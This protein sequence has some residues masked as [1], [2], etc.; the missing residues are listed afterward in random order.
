EL[1]ESQTQLFQTAKLATLGEMSTGMAHEMN[2]PMAG[3]S[4]AVTTIKK[5]KEKNRLTDE[6]LASALKDIE[7]SVTRCTKIIRHVRAFARQEALKF[8]EV[9]VNETVSSAL[10]LLAEQLKLRGIEVTQSLASTLPKIQGEPYQLEQV[11][12]NMISNA[13][14]ALEERETESK[15]NNETNYHMQLSLSTQLEGERIVVEITDNGIGMTEE[16][17][18]KVF[19]PF[20]TTKPVGKGTGLGMSIVYGILESHQAKTEIK[21][22]LKKGTSMAVSLR[23]G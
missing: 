21:S 13:R 3:I 9:D 15:A 8:T 1:A 14:D 12:I 7:N 16:V 23:L 6:E 4:L 2:Q 10:M 11:W 5:L 22:E 17:K 20:F 19:E 18:K